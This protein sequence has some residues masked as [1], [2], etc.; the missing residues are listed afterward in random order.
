MTIYS[1]SFFLNFEPGHI[2]WTFS[3]PWLL[4]SL[5]LSTPQSCG[6]PWYTEWGNKEVELFGRILNSWGIQALIHT[7]LFSPWEKLQA[8][9]VSWPW[10]VPPLG[11]DNGRLKNYSSY[12]LQ[13]VWSW[14][15]VLCVLKLLCRTLVLLQSYSCQNQCSLGKRCKKT[16]TKT[17][18]FLSSC[19]VISCLL[20]F[21]NA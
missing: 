9:L 17:K 5:L 20:Y 1:L 16:K 8:K 2:S 3:K 10:V 13:Y 19:S 11:R 4:F 21:Q 12:T 14:I 7:H 15:F 6:S 18:L